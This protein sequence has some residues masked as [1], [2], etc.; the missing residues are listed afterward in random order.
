VKLEKNQWRDLCRRLACQSQIACEWFD[1]IVKRYNEPQRHYHNAEHIAHCLAEFRAAS[2]LAENPAEVE[3]ALWLHDVI[4]DP[5]RA[6]NEEQSAEFA[7][8]FCREAGIEHE[9]VVDLIFATKHNVAPASKDSRLVVDID[10]AILGQP[11][12]RFW[13]YEKEIREEYAFVAEDVFRMKRGEILEKILQC[14]RVYASEFFFAKY[15]QD[16]RRNLKQSVERL[17]A[18]E[19]PKD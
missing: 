18:R 10:L 16:A 5:R 19:I 15:E 3:L 7:R 17:R 9:R 4:Y 2:R 8:T 12:E 14:E 6:D 1:K 13:R 11:E